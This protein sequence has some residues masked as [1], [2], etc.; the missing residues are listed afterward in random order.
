MMDLLGIKQLRPPVGHSIHSPNPV[1]YD[2]SKANPYPN[3][4]NP[5]LLNNGKPVTTT[6]MWWKERRPQIMEMFSRDVYG[7]VPAHM[8]KVTWQVLSTTRDTLG[9]VPEVRQHLAGHVDNAIDPKISVTL[10]LVVATPANAPGPVPVIMEVA[11]SPETMATI[12]RFIPEM[13][14]GG[15]GNTGP[16]WQVQVLRRGWGYAVLLPTSL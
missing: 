16:S 4:P 8:P 3:L 6:R 14:P 15:P 2:E 1:N 5:L 11:F 7:R 9:G 13:A 12:A 10:D